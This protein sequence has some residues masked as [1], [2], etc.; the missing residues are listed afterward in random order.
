MTSTNPVVNH[1]KMLTLL[2]TNKNENVCNG[3]TIL[4]P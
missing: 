3:K 1:D 4:L 2:S